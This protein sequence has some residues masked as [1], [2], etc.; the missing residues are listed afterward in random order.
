MQFRNR[1]ILVFDAISLSVAP[2]LLYAIRFESWVWPAG[3]RATAIAFDAVHLP[4]ALA[5]CFAFGMYGRL[6][7]Y[8]GTAELE[9]IAAASAAV[10]CADVALGLVIL[11][12]L[13][14]PT[15]VPLSVL[16]SL[17]LLSL[18]TLAA[19]RI[20]IRVAG[21]RSWSQRRRR[22]DVRRAFIAGAGAAGEMILKELLA[23]AELGIQPI[24]FIDDDETKHGLTLRG[25]PVLGRLS[26][27]ERINKRVHADELIIAMPRASGTIVREVVRAAYAAGLKTRTIPGLYEILSDRVRVSA[28][29]EVQIEDLLRRD[30]IETDL[31]ALSTLATGKTVLVTGAGGSIGS[32]LCRQ[33]IAL[34]P[35]RLVLLGHGENAIFDI[36]QEIRA[37]A[38]ACQITEVIADIRDADRVRRVFTQYRPYA[39]F[40]AAAHKHVPLME[41]N[42]VE[43]ITNNILGTGNVVAASVSTGVRHFVL[44]SSDK[45]VRPGNIMGATKRIAE[46]VVHLA[47]V[48]HRRNFVAVRFGNVLGSRGSVVPTFARQIQAGGPVTVTDPE[49]RRYFMTIPEAVQLVLQAGALGKGGEVFLLDMGEPIRIV[50][51]ARDMIRL[52]GLREGD[53][54]EIQFTGRRAGEKLYEEMFFSHEV[55]EATN[56]P[57]I[58]RARNGESTCTVDA[59]QRLTSSAQRGVSDVQLRR[60]LKQLV[61]DFAWTDTGI[62]ASDDSMDAEVSIVADAVTAVTRHV[63]GPDQGLSQLSA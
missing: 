1:H 50:D 42:V 48:K 5:I 26:E 37:S 25:V 32:E 35:T 63:A 58:L 62:A 9:V 33:L 11:P 52:S 47:A 7:R 53:D 23:N 41:E 4:V 38:A 17:G 6:W 13:L 14:T 55:A 8:A 43:A 45:A 27:L 10:T 22:T 31:A 29:R 51:L 30:P 15:R 3:H 39:V 46:H 59:V 19:P 12:R 34:Q 54:I 18:F 36:A 2:I 40:H 57:K 21:M 60:M 24:G 44:I 16:F 20:F 61:P 56:H 49:M 28:I